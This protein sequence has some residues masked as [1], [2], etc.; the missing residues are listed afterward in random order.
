MNRF[1]PS[2]FHRHVKR[3]RDAWSLLEPRKRLEQYRSGAPRARLRGAVV[4]LLIARRR[5][6]YDFY[7]VHNSG[8]TDEQKATS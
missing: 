2:T 6:F 5:Y 7:F 8:W 1:Q 4:S 3:F